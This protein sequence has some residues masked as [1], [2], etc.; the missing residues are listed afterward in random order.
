MKKLIYL[1]GMMLLCMNVMAQIDLNDENWEEALYD[2]FISAG[3]G[4]NTYNF[5]ELTT[6]EHPNAIWWCGAGA[7]YPCTVFTDEY[8]HQVYQPS[9]CV[10][11]NN[12]LSLISEYTGEDDLSCANGDYILP[13]SIPGAT[14][15]NC[16][17]PHNNYLSGMIQSL[18]KFGFGYYEIRY[19]TPAHRDAHVGFWVF[20]GGPETYEE[21]D[22]MEYSNGD[23]Q[24]DSLYGYSSGIWHNP[25]GIY[26]NNPLDPNDYAINYAKSYYHLPTNE[27]D[28]SEYH[29]FGLEWMPDYVKWYRDGN[30]VSEYRNREHIPQYRKWILVTYEIGTYH[31]SLMWFGTDELVI[32]YIKVYELKTD[33]SDDVF[34]RTISDWENFEPRVK[35]TI[36]IGSTNGLIV[37]QNQNQTFRASESILIDQPF[38]LPQGVQMSLIVQEC[39][40]NL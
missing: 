20:G 3:R 15:E 7:F 14:C 2:G 11:E 33:C 30:V 8:H 6:L 9:Q 38:E 24:D 10:F 27:P 1:C 32:D 16:E 17:Q 23:C 34:I 26:A 37:P 21:I 25:N 39:P 4:W 19:K 28:L 29:T 13:Q 40:E 31:G 36:S 18:P 5:H 12:V 22:I 35:N